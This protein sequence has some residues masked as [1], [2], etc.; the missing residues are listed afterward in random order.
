MGLE[1]EEKEDWGGG[2]QKVYN[3]GRLKKEEM[4]GWDLRNCEDA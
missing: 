1:E 4:E 2:R 3:V